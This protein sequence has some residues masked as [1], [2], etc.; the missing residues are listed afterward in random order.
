MAYACDIQNM[1]THKGLTR[2]MSPFDYVI[3][4]LPGST[5]DLA[6]FGGKAW[7]NFYVLMDLFAVYTYINPVRT[8]T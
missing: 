8:G 4:P 6:V 2:K 3:M 7:A 5:R 1:N